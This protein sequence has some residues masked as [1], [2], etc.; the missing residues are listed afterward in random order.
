MKRWAQER[1]ASASRGSW[2]RALAQDILEDEE[3]DITS[4][5]GSWEKRAYYALCK[6]YDGGSGSWRARLI[7]ELESAESPEEPE[8]EPEPPGD[9]TE[10]AG[11]GFGRRMYATGRYG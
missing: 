3:V 4:T 7:Q 8:P 11:G 6:T 10:L 2:S 5:E 1:G 9:V